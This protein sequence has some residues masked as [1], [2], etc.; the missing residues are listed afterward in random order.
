[1]PRSCC[2]G[3]LLARARAAALSSPHFMKNRLLALPVLLLATQAFGQQVEYSGRASASFSNFR[4]TNATSSSVVNYN[5]SD[6]GS[7][8]TLNPYGKHLGAGFGAS[9]RVQHVGKAGLLTA[10]DLGYDFMQARTA[11]SSVNYN[12]SVAG[13]SRP[14]SATT[15]LYTQTVS[16][17]ASVGWRLRGKAL[18]LDALVGPE[19]ACLLTAREASSGTTTTGEWSTDTKRSPANSLDFRL[20]GD[21]TVWRK[22]VG[23][24]ASYAYGFTNYEP[25]TSAISAPQAN[26][27]L[28]R[29]GLA[30][31]FK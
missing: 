7:S 26:A 29:V 5:T 10:F 12:N 3:K 23:L 24:A 4:G 25:H 19:L 17:F 14:T 31:R 9:G 1:M 13:Y 30:Y 18:A 11:I 6:L 21:L 16:A 2:P 28:I 15:H 20:R 8:S 22:R 27:G